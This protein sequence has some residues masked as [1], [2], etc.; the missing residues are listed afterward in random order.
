M[1][2]QPAATCCFTGHRPDKLPSGYARDPAAC[3][4]L[5]EALA[6]VIRQTAA[7]GFDTF[8]CGMALGADTWAAEEVLRLRDEEG[9]PLRLIGALPCPEQDSRWQPADRQHYR[10]LLARLDG[11]HLI[12]EHYT[13]WC[14]NARNRWMVEH[15]ARLIAVFDGSPG[16]TANTIQYASQKGLEL[17]IIPPSLNPPLL[18]F[19]K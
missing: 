18:H 15:A 12:S 10:R 2:I 3:A 14:M 11:Q 13:S 4:P 19:I 1:D 9:V 17:F 6:R 5:R 7:A 16:G 8:W